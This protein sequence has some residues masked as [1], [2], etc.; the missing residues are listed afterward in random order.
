MRGKI[1]REMPRISPGSSSNR[2][3]P[4]EGLRMACQLFSQTLVYNNID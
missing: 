2:H 1:G 3:R 4:N